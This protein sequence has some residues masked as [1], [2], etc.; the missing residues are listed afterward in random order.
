VTARFDFS[1]FP[2]LATDRLVLREFRVGDATALFAFRSDADEQKYNAEPLTTV[3][4]AV[5]MIADLHADYAAH[6][7]IHWAVAGRDDDRVIGLFDYVAWER[8]HRRA[9]IGYDLAKAH[10]G[11]GLATEALAA[12][13]GFGFTQMDLMRVEAQTIADNHESVRLLRRLGFRL[14]G[15]RRSFSLEADGNDHDGAIY[16]LLREEFAAPSTL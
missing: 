7:A 10:W 11:S 8:D 12:M 14:E 3:D 4:Q 6:T 13:L 1:R 9:E 2:T 15:L 16:G 5:A